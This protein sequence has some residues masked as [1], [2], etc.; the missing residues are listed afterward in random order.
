M[1]PDLPRPHVTPATAPRALASTLA[2]ATEA[3]AHELACELASVWLYTGDPSTL[4]C[5]DLYCRALDSHTSAVRLPSRHF[6]RYAAALAGACDD[7]NVEAAPILLHGR[8]VGVLC[9]E[10]GATAPGFTADERD[11]AAALTEPIVALLEAAARH[12]TLPT[13]APLC[14]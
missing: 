11:A 8:R 5:L 12:V 9:L 2:A 14:A 3:A 6:D 1:L 4:S 10:R 7:A 13:V